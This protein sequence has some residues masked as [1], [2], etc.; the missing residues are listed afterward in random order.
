VNLRSL[1]E[2]DEGRVR[3]AYQDHMGYWTLGVGRL[4]DSRKGGGLSDEEIDFL[5]DN[6]I[7][8]KTAEVRKALPWFDRLDEV[9]QAVLVSMAFQMGTAGLLKFKNTLALIERGDYPAAAR[10]MLESLW[11]KQTP[12]RAARLA[13]MMEEGAW[14]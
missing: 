13:D 4:I 8:A 7:K 5:L 11:A 3:H 14:V 12:L 2:R 1:L 10:G 9:R 6:D